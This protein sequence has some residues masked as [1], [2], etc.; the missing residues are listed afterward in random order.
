MPKDSRNADKSLGI[1][2]VVLII[3]DDLFL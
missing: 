2:Y 1:L 3:F